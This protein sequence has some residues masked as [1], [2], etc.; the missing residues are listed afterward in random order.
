MGM[1]IGVIVVAVVAWGGAEAVALDE[2]GVACID[3]GFTVTDGP[4]TAANCSTG[5]G[6]DT[7]HD[8]WTV[9]NLRE[10]GCPS[11]PGDVE[12]TGTT[13]RV[14]D[15]NNSAT[16]G[17]N[18]LYRAVDTPPSEWRLT[19]DVLV[20]SV[21]DP[22][23]RPVPG[24]WTQFVN[25][26]LFPGET[27]NFGWAAG[28]GQS[29]NLRDSSG[30]IGTGY[31]LSV[32]TW[33]RVELINTTAGSELRAWPVSGA[34]PATAQATG[35]DLGTANRVLFNG[36]NWKNY[37]YEVDNVELLTLDGRF[38]DLGLGL[39]GAYGEPVATGSGLLFPGESTTIALSNAIE[40]APSFMFIG[41]TR[42]DHAPF[43]GGTL[44]PD[45]LSAG[46]GLFVLVTDG[47]GDID[48]TGPW[49]NAPQGLEAFLQFWVEDGAGAFGFSASNA[50]KVTAP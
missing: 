15:S 18:G 35:G 25:T 23:N 41:L 50:V 14:W 2:V 44:V 9:V 48:L 45:F 46:G 11:D 5:G 31:T 39:A 38:E 21:Q 17:Y 28:S 29:L 20:N 47:G 33:H 12:F 16:D 40:S 42:L 19:V 26:T 4:W 7:G 1:Q 6:T 27:T 34:R 32:G 49:P 13:A 36:P 8:G 37:D 3:E 10:V 43:Y 22:T 24:A 30:A